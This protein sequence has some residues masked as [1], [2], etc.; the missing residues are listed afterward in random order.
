MGSSKGEEKEF[1]REMEDR[2]EAKDGDRSPDRPGPVGE[3]CGGVAVV[4]I[5][6]DCESFNRESRLLGGTGGA[7]LLVDVLGDINDGVRGGAGAMSFGG[8]GLVRSTGSEKEN[9]GD[10][11]NWSNRS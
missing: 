3:N 9:G 4:L 8:T 10:S 6:G 1:G 2:E 7:G 11:W 5:G